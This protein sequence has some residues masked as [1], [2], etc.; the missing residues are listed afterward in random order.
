MD[1]GGSSPLTSISKQNKTGSDY[2][3]NRHDFLYKVNIP[4]SKPDRSLRHSDGNY[5]DQFLEADEVVRIAR[6]EFEA[7]GVSDCRYE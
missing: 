1:V 3:G 4:R 7:I 5:V 6:I 2:I